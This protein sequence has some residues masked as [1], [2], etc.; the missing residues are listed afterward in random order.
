VN[1][2]RNA[3][4]AET[5]GVAAPGFAAAPSAQWQLR[6]RIARRAGRA[7]PSSRRSDN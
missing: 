1:N 3:T 6:E 2:T 7:M 5:D 4:F